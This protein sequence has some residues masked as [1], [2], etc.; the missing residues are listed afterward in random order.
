MGMTIAGL[1]GCST[2]RTANLSAEIVDLKREFAAECEN[3]TGITSLYE[4][5]LELIVQERN[6]KLKKAGVA[7]DEEWY[8]KETGNGYEPLFSQTSFPNP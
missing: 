8:C 6:E 5:S 1:Y 7:N 4:G 2:N 3:K